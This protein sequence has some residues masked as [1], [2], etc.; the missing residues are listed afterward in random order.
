M[1]RC[2]YGERQWEIGYTGIQNRYVASIGKV[3]VF[4]DCIDGKPKNT[5]RTHNIYIVNVNVNVNI[6]IVPCLKG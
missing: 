2:N 3:T 4:H 5:M 6:Y 1:F